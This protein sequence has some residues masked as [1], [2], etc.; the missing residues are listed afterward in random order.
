MVK[1]D[2][3]AKTDHPYDESESVSTEDVGDLPVPLKMSIH[4]LLE[5][6]SAG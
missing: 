1:G 6:P 3:T 5:P 4:V 2:P